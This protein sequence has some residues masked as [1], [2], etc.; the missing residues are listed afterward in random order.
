ELAA[1]NSVN[2]GVVDSPVFRILWRRLAMRLCKLVLAVGILAL[3]STPALA[4]RGGG[5]GGLGLGGLI[6]NKSVQ[7][8]LK[9]DKETVTKAQDALKKVNE[10]NKDAADK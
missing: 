9:L 5:R 4:Q 7:E 1:A 10:D 8:E 6:G 3:L 2:T